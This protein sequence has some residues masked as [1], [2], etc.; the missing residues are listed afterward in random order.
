MLQL[1][2]MLFRGQYGTPMKTLQ[3]SVRHSTKKIGKN[4]IEFELYFNFFSFPS[5][6]VLEKKKIENFSEMFNNFQLSH[7]G[8]GMFLKFHKLESPFPNVVFC[9][10]WLKLANVVLKKMLKM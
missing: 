5:Q 1:S 6:M 3:I 4:I 10:V 2:V 7:L 8:K 9:Q